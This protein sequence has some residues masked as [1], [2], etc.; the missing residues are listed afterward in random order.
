MDEA[1]AHP[2]PAGSYPGSLLCYERAR[3]VIPGGIHLSGRPLLDPQTS[4][5]YFERASGC[6]VWDVDG[7]QYIDYL[8][9][10]GAYLLGYAHPEVEAAAFTQA[11]RGRLISL[12]HPQ[13]VAFIEA[14]LAR[15]PG[16]QM[17]VF[18]KTGSEATTAALRIARRATGRRRVARCGYHGWHDWCLPLEDYVPDGLQAQVLEF[19]AN[20][21]ATLE[22]IFAAYP[23]ELAAVILA[24]EMVRPLQPA[25]FA[26]LQRLTR[27]S[28][29]LFIMDEVKTG[30]RIWPNSI[31][32][33]VGIIPDLLTVSKALGNGFPVAALLGRREFMQAGDGM[34][35][36]ATFHGDTAAMAAARKT[37]ELVESQKVQQHVHTLGERLIAG[38]SALAKE[39]GLPA[40]AYGEPLPP[41]PFFRF[42]HASPQVN[43]RLG[44]A[45]YG[46]MLARGVL[47]H[48]RHMWFISLAHT[49][50]D[51]DQ[52]LAA[53]DRAMRRASRELS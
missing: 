20:Q 45:F 37:M 3:K 26:E 23:G 42:T 22:A 43:V 1:Q 6:R 2:E 8:M 34:H 4:P 44:Q 16:L 10:F 18:F 46:E 19:D 25:V 50:D 53:A 14:L 33:R 11:Q 27:Q 21:P 29:A 5:M 13:H 39:H 52:T 32:E 9:A 30:L 49:P 17:G 38:L 35:Y 31:S 48:P 40:E 51:I 12:N 36:S 41:M 15:F 24:P 47:M 28:G 7:N